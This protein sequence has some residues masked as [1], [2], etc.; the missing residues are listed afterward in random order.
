MQML[1][2]HQPFY[3]DKTDCKCYSYK[4]LQRK[5][6]DHKRLDILKKDHMMYAGGIGTGKTELVRRSPQD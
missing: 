5:K 4:Y 6:R 3:M 2:P 1:P